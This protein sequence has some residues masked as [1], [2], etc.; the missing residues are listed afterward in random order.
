MSG[1]QQQPLWARGGALSASECSHFCALT[2]L[3]CSLQNCRAKA[4]IDSGKP[5]RT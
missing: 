2:L 4:V 1:L 5:L 3:A